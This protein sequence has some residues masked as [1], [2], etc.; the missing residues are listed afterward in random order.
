VTS[1]AEHGKSQ[2]YSLD[3]D[4]QLTARTKWDGTRPVITR[5]TRD[6]LGRITGVTD[7]DLGLWTYT[8]DAA[9]RLTSQTDAK[10]HVTTLAYDA[11][12]R[13]ASKTVTGAGH[14]I[15]TTTLSY[16]QLRSGYLNLGSLTTANRSTLALGA[17][18]AAR[19]C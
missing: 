12:S 17:V 5:Y 14:P 6:V 1:T 8:Y 3:S 9:S 16:D 2:T 13:V 4:G 11:L 19:C 18:S 10:A 15:E 7:P